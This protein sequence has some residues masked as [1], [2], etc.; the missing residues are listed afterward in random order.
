MVNRLLLE[1]SIDINLATEGGATPLLTCCTFGKLDVL[2]RLLQED[3]IDVNRADNDGDTPLLESLRKGYKDIFLKLMHYN[4]AKGVCINPTNN[5][6]E[7]VFWRACFQGDV[8]LVSWYLQKDRG[9]DINQAKDNGNTPL[10]AACNQGQLDTVNLLLLQNSIEINRANNA[11]YTPL[12]TAAISKDAGQTRSDV[13]RRL[14]EEESIDVGSSLLALC[15]TANKKTLDRLS[16]ATGSR[17]KEVVESVLQIMEASSA[18]P[19]HRAGMLEPCSFS[20]EDTTWEFESH[21]GRAKFFIQQAGKVFIQH[22]KQDVSYWD[23]IVGR[24]D[25]LVEVDLP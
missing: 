23:S 13:V 12:H 24:I 19:G 16:W 7:S 21:W 10:F 2:D 22:V 11:G 9:I 4:Q 8:D 17:N 3:S 20:G 18:E 1:D 25:A 6:G 5:N 15:S 14:L